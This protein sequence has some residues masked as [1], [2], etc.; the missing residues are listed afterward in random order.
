MM[1]DISRQLELYIETRGG[2]LGDSIQL[3]EHYLYIE[4]IIFNREVKI[5][6]VYDRDEFVKMNISDKIDFV[7]QAIL[8]HV[9]RQSK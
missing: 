7:D 2:V 8:T 1:R 6:E 5:R 3:C 4:L 9:L